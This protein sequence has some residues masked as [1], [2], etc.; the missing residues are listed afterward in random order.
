MGLQKSLAS[1]YNITFIVLFLVPFVIGLTG[2][3]VCKHLLNKTAQKTL[4][5][6]NNL[7]EQNAEQIKL[8][9]Q[10]SVL[11][12]QASISV[13]LTVFR[14]ILYETCFFG[15]ILAGYL[16]WVSIFSSFQSLQLMDIV[17]CCVIAVT[18]LGYAILY[19]KKKTGNFS[20]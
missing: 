8:E 6:K 20:L 11:A 1:N 7:L 5:A 16:A 10:S 9:S 2:L 14:R 4:E 18:W 15:L 13:K 19:A 12:E 17:F 3:L